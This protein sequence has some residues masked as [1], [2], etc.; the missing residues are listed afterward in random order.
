MEL[1]EDKLSGN[2]ML[3]ANNPMEELSIINN[4]KKKRIKASLSL[5]FH[6]RLSRS[7]KKLKNMT[8]QNFIQ[9]LKTTP[10]T[11]T[12]AETKQVIEDHYNFTP[13]AFTNGNI[14]NKAGEN[15]GS[16]KLFTFA[17]HQ[18][19]TTAATLV[20]FSEHYKSVLE[21]TFGASHQNIRNFMQTGFQGLTF[22]QDAL[23]LK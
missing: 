11:I 5:K 6:G 8:L 23:T 9:K 13:T 14:K 22:E 12:V 3:F 1:V 18:K 7:S 17:V 15:N 2:F 4:S 20:C 19:F 21:D 10:S 16:C